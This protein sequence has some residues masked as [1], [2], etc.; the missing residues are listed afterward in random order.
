M[1]HRTPDFPRALALVLRSPKGCRVSEG[2]CLPS[3][4]LTIHRNQR[5]ANTETASRAASAVRARL[6]EANHV[7]TNLRLAIG[8]P[9]I[10]KLPALLEDIGAA[11]G[12]FDLAADLMAHCLLDDSMR[13]GRD[14]F[15]PGPKGG[16]EAVRGDRLAAR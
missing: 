3:R 13:E 10:H 12:S 11:I 14:L 1:H 9:S 6:G 16:A 4:A 2:A 7:R 8:G 15:G 5:R